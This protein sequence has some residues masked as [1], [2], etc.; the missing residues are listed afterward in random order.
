M[1]TSP[2]T[3]SAQD[4]AFSQEILRKECENLSNEI[5]RLKRQAQLQEGRLMNAIALASSLSS[6]LN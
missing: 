2:M 3:F 6:N 5:Y 1:G 4:R